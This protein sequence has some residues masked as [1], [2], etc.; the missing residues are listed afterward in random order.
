MRVAVLAEWYP[1]PVDPVLGV[2]AHRQAVAARDAGAEV[3]IIVAR[4]PIPPRSVFRAGPVAVAR[5]LRGVRALMASFDLDGIRISAAPFVS[6]PRPLSY[7]VWGYWMAPSVAHALDELYA[8]WP[9]DVVHAHCI[10]PPGFAAARWVQK[11]NVALAVSTHGPDVTSVYSLSRWAERATGFAL[12]RADVVIANSRWAADRCEMIAGH[13]LPT[14]IV[15]LGAHPPLKLPERRARPTIVTL[16]H[17]TA[18]KRHVVVL[19]A[20]AALPEAQRPDYLIIGEGPLRGQIQ[21]V[22]RELGVAD[23]LQMLGQIDN[24]SALRELA[25]CH[26]FVMPSVDEPFGVAYVEAM[27]AGLPAIGVRGVGGPEEIAAAGDGIVL[28]PR[29]DHRALA[30]AIAAELND[31]DQLAA[32]AAA[33]R[34][35]VMR[36]FTWAHCGRRMVEAYMRALAQHR[37]RL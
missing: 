35:T 33:A 9:F 23:R 26:L 2:W 5:W 7:G 25:R 22:G 28:V 15:H 27:A 32:R 24:A 11:R 19:H 3:R 6:P 4:R 12:D 13:A 1:S 30:A 8:Q 14:E 18:S 34:D 20:L 36:H 37:S 17:L 31:S 21:R 16:A 10:T 29:D